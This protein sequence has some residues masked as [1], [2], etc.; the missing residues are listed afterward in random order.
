MMNHE[1][2][3]GHEERYHGGSFCA[4]EGLGLLEPDRRLPWKNAAFFFYWAVSYTLVPNR[5]ENNSM[6]MY[7]KVKTLTPITPCHNMLCTPRSLSSIY[8][9]H[10]LIPEVSPGP[11]ILFCLP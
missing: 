4:E 6:D 8:Q 11:E 1:V 10:H 9:L 2:Q 7:A 5:P 3:I